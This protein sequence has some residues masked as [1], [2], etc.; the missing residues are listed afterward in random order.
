MEH[1]QIDFVI[2][3]GFENWII[4]SFCLCSTTDETFLRNLYPSRRRK[5]LLG[6]ACDRGDELRSSQMRLF[7][8]SWQMSRSVYK[9]TPLFLNLSN[10]FVAKSRSIHHRF[11]KQVPPR[12]TQPEPS[13]EG[14]GEHPS[15]R[16]AVFLPLFSSFPPFCH[17]CPSLWLICNDR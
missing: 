13:G 16:A 2:Q 3:F 7:Y 17:V 5:P 11:I 12:V 6:K 10:S 4:K 9:L 15:P 14:G 1:R 8:A